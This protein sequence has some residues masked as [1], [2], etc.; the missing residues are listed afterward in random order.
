MK[1]AE[2][3]SS[4]DFLVNHCVAELE[5][6]EAS[7]GRMIRCISDGAGAV[8]EL[9]DRLRA[10]SVTFS[11]LANEVSGDARSLQKAY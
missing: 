9:A 6:L 4:A 5:E 3:T 11:K 7:Y 2:N 10:V 1:T 8:P